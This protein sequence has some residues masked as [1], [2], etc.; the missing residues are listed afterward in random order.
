[1]KINGVIYA[2]L[3]AAEAGPRVYETFSQWTLD[4]ADG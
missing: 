1:M 4:N 2:E 3:L